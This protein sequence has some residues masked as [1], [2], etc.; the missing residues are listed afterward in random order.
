M[1]STT[2]A[3]GDAHALHPD[4]FD[5]AAIRN[6]KPF[7]PWLHGE[8]R[9][10]QVGRMSW[11]PFIFILNRFGSL[12][13]LPLTVYLVR[14]QAGETGAIAIY[15]GARWALGVRQRYRIF[16]QDYPAQQYEDALQ[17]FVEE[18]EG[19]ERQHLV[20]LNMFL[21][22]AGDKSIFLPIWRVAGFSLGAASTLWCPR[23]M[24]VTT[25]AVETF[26]EE[27]YVAQILRLES[28]L[29]AAQVFAA[30][31]MFWEFFHT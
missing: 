4:D 2:S 16:M 14:C 23:G 13:L 17:A 25:D 5:Y 12:S 8:M 18:H 24:Y 31:L 6:L 28:E 10:N 27:H 19:S 29:Q 9:S 20:A 26:V 11:V 22:E 1:L 21:D 3:S 30:V 7:H 15:Q